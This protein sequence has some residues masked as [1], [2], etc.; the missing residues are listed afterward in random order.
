MYYY[1]L[2]WIHI[3]DETALAS[4][5]HLLL[6]LLFTLDTSKGCDQGSIITSF[7][8]IIICSGYI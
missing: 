1:C 2:H 7:I 5:R 3:N 4:K 8:I 6:L